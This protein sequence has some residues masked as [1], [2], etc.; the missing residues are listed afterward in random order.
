MSSSMQSS[1]HS[2]AFYE[3]PELHSA[4]NSNDRSDTD[5]IWY[6]WHCYSEGII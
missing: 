3:A 5:V 4:P 6:H 2:L 1:K